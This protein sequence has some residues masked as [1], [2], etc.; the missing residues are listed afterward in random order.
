[1]ELRQLRES[2]GLTIEHVAQTLECSDSKVSRIE[3][4]QVSATPRDVRDMLEI[5]GISGQHRDELMQIAREARQKG[6]WHA[7]GDVPVPP[8]VA[9]EVEAYSMSIFYSLLVPGLFQIEDY[10]RA[11]MRA[12]RPDLPARQID[13]RV[14]LRMARQTLLVKDEPPALWVVLDEAALRRHIGGRAVMHQ[15]LERL[16]EVA[17]LPNVTLQVLPFTS[18]EHAGLDGDFTIIGFPDPADPNVVCISMTTSDVWLEEAEVVR[19]YDHMFDLL[20]AGAL[21][22]AESI[23]FFENAASECKV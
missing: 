18:G 5:Y 19:Q 22:P 17:A 23:T 14:E 21:S 6:W 1:M 20:R 8:V 4:G 10:A 13:R 11:V 3:T 16:I 15:Q 9:F 12:I 7:Y 2:A